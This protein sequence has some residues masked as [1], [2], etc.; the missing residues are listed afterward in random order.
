[1][2]MRVFKVG[3]LDVGDQTHSKRLRIVLEAGEMFWRQV[4]GDDDLFL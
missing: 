4:A 1:M 2:A 3:C